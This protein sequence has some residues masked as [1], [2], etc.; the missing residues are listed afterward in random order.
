ML[1]QMSNL[2][3]HYNYPLRCKSLFVF[4]D[5]R[6]NLHETTL[7]DDCEQWGIFLLEIS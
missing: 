2:P 3:T 6:N 1:S 4:V 7:T 5:A